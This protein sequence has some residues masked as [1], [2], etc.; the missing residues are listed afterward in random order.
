MLTQQQKFDILTQD[1]LQDRDGHFVKIRTTGRLGWE[2]LL[3]EDGAYSSMILSPK[4]DEDLL[5]NAVRIAR[6][7]LVSMNPGRP[8]RLFVHPETS[9]TNGHNVWVATN[10]LDD[11]RLSVGKR[12][13]TFLGFTVHEGSHVLY[14]D[15]GALDAIRNRLV[16]DLQNI[17]EDERIERLLGEDKPGLANYLKAEK[18]YVFDQYI[19]QTDQTG[20]NELCRLLNCILMYVRYPASL[21][22]DDV[23]EFADE[24][25]KVKEILTPYPEST[26]G[27]IRAAEAIYEVLRRF[28]P[29]SQ[30][31][32]KDDQGEGES[33]KSS[34]KDKSGEEKQRSSSASG[35]GEDTESEP[36]NG[37]SGSD[38]DDKDKDKDDEREGSGSGKDQ[39]GEDE[40]E[41]RAGND[42]D[43]ED[44]DGNDNKDN[45]DNPDNNDT[46][47]NSDNSDNKDNKNNKN[48]KSNKEKN[49]TESSGKDNSSSSDPSDGDGSGNGADDD[50]EG[51]QEEL[52]QREPM[53]DEELMDALEDLLDALKALSGNEKCQGEQDM[54][55]AAAK[56]DGLLAKELD[57]LLE[58]GKDHNNVFIEALSDKASY[59]SSLSRVS[60]F[61]PAIRRA[62]T[63]NDFTADYT[64]LGMRSGRLDTNKLAEARQS[65]QTVYTRTV[66]AQPRP[67]NVVLLIDESGSMHH[68]YILCRDAAV[69][70]QEAVENIP[71][72]RLSVYGY[73][74]GN[75][76]NVLITHKDHWDKHPDKYRIGSISA[77]GST[78]TR[79]AIMEITARI[80]ERSGDRTILFVLSDGVP[81]STHQAVRNAVDE[82]TRKGITVIGISVASSLTENDLKAMYGHYLV[83]NDNADLPKE[84]GKTIKK[85]II[86]AH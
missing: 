33:R 44:S 48:N 18:Y 72:I 42:T 39:S 36:R 14:T 79:E 35:T 8:L 47:S 30:A 12:L 55:Q 54:S 58:R 77:Y 3:P 67:M 41:S 10:V 16:G 7:V 84:L 37:G 56:D 65:V 32:G 51:D 5:K 64:L 11:Q 1:L 28:I 6:Q 66:K 75:P 46:A 74:S 70:I 83:M 43:K 27:S 68:R 34:S 63:D 73:T 53:T 26:E 61:I 62:L 4:D 19:N 59:L 38:D 82:A 45:S 76:K 57:G 52:P 85:A 24:L 13:D 29:K 86:K 80:T 78:P 60:R 17:I 20:L 15:F 2:D 22:K 9:M 40:S 81:D 69:L 49:G 71:D 50:G 25:M 31:G 23:M 21:N